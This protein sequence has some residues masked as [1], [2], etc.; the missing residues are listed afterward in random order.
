M[1]MELVLA[2]PLAEISAAVAG[3]LVVVFGIHAFR[4]FLRV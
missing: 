4:A 3:G 2:W 1:R